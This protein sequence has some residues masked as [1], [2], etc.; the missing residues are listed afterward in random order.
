MIKQNLIHN[1]IVNKLEEQ[2]KKTKIYVSVTDFNFMVRGGRAS[3]L[4]GKVAKLLN[5]KPIISL[6]EKGKGYSFANAL[7][8]EGN[9]KKIKEIVIETKKKG[10]IKKYGI[11]HGNAPEKGEEYSKIF[12]EL[13]GIKPEFIQEISSIVALSAGKGAATLCIMEE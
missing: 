7:S 8:Q 2:K 3:P 4:K 5:F 6:D 1:E 13:I 9:L 11:V 12:T 10:E